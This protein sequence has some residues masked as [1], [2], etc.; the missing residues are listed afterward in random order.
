MDKE[1]D[2]LLSKYKESLEQL[3][4][5]NTKAK[6]VDTSEQAI[7]NH[8]S[9]KHDNED[10]LN[11][12]ISKLRLDVNSLLNKRQAEMSAS[13]LAVDLFIDNTIWNLFSRTELQND[14]LLFNNDQKRISDKKHLL[15]LIT[16]L[17]KFDQA[18][19]LAHQEDTQDD[20]S[21][22]LHQWM[23][24]LI[25]IYLRL[26]SIH[27]KKKV[28]QLLK[29]TCH[30][31][32]WAIP[33]IQFSVHDVTDT[34]NY[35]DILDIV[36]LN[37]QENEE[38]NWTEDDFVGVLDQLA[39]DYNYSK[40]LD[41]I[42]PDDDPFMLFQYSQNMT[43]SLMNAI[44]RFTAMKS[45]VKRL[46]QTVIQMALLLVDAVHDKGWTCQDKI[47]SFLCQMVY[48]FHDL[49]KDG[50][51]FLP[52]MPYK[53]LS[54]DAL[55]QVTTYLLQNKD[56]TQPTSLESVL[57]EQ[58]PNLARFQ[59]ELHDN[60]NQGFFMLS[61]LTN[62]VTC[63]PPGVDEVN[64][65]NDPESVL[66]A[67]I[68]TIL[69]FTLFHVAFI[70][71]TLREIF[72]RDV[73]DNL[74]VI[75]RHHP[76]VISLVFRWTVQHMAIME[77][78]ALYLFHSI[79]LDQWIAQIQLAK[80]IIEQLNYGYRHGIDTQLSKSQPW[81]PRQM[82][83]LPYQTHEEIAFILLDACQKFQPI[84][85]NLE[86]KSGAMD[87]VS[88]YLP[89]ADQLLKSAYAPTTIQNSKDISSMANDFIQW[90]WSVAI[91]LKLYDCPISPRATNID[92]SITLP[93]LKA[94]LNSFNHVS[95]S[96]SALIVYVSFLL[97]LLTI[98]K[99]GKPE[100]VIQIFS[101]IIPSFVYMHGD[102]FFNDESLPDFFKHLVHFKSDPMLTKASQSFL[103]HHKVKQPTMTGVGFMM[104][105]HMWQVHLIDSVSHLLDESGKGFSYVDLAMHSWLK[106]VFRKPDWM[107]QNAYVSMVDM[108][109]KLAFVL[110]RHPLIHHMLLEEHK[111]METLKLQNNT[112]GSP[113]LTRFIKNMMLVT[114]SPFVSLLIGEWSMLNLKANT[115]NKAPGV[116]PCMHWFAFQVLIVETMTES[117][118]RDEI[119]QVLISSSED[120]KTVP[121]I[122]TLYKQTLSNAKKPIEYFS[123]YRWLQHILVVPM[124]HP[125][126]P[127]YFQM[128]FSLYYQPLNPKFTLGALF[129]N[130][131][132]DLLIKLRDYVANVQTYY[133]QKIMAD[134]GPHIGAL[135]QFYYAL[136]LWLG[137]QDILN[138][139]VNIKELPS[140]YDTQRLSLCYNKVEI[141][142]PWHYA[143]E[144]Y[145]MDLVDTDQLEQ[146][147]L[148]FPWEGADKFRTV[149][150]VGSDSSMHPSL[151]DD[152]LS[153]STTAR[154]LRLITDE[155]TIEPLPSVIIH[156]PTSSTGSIRKKI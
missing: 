108:L 143:N 123:I 61:C 6:E 82:P 14:Q 67:H 102:D 62:I 68:I 50:W 7:A 113:R 117:V 90:A 43:D 156:Q 115:F 40:I 114:D 147:F 107:W 66:S 69:S 81:H 39:I 140:H 96:H 33:L 12:I 131:K 71:K 93:F 122:L 133:G 95:S 137:N 134:A 124:D 83:F 76:F 10:K 27:E 129:F 55:W 121:D 77:R 60:Q 4:E 13:K 155:S 98:L 20:Y 41:S 54:I 46:S 120:K 89:I 127:L 138:G 101:E 51:F 126:L 97:S 30:I 130:K 63:I 88:S 23:T 105:S 48:R 24:K 118:F 18:C 3:S 111:R 38:S 35:K 84:P 153:L 64:T 47:D 28:L 15:K 110:N 109:C 103:K 141:E 92:T 16:T 65:I 116:E 86:N 136:W 150:S 154:R 9:D 100:A 146:E 5:I 19:Q 34:D 17:F 8:L 22:Q 2:A 144:H 21:S 145:W 52:N 37:K 85:D 94:V 59:Y 75:C 36:F 135:Q 42:G 53:A 152:R 128:F 125:L 79:K 70:D 91:R 106:T 44:C 74:C 139:Q 148:N 58:L 29:T 142:Q 11:Q 119:T 80:Y 49:K 112:S 132:Q 72:Y 32:S 78:M 149:E 31:S 151:L 73:R 26:C 99:R 104:G 56:K 1:L 87:M 25:T 57:N 45:L